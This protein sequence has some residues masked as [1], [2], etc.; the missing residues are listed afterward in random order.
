MNGIENINFVVCK[1]CNERFRGIRTCHLRKSHDMTL[2]QYLQQFP[3][4]VTTCQRA[5]DEI[6]DSLKNSE[7][8][9]KSQAS[10]ERISKIGRPGRIQTSTE[11]QKRIESRKRFFQTP[12]GLVERQ[13][14]SQQKRT[15]EA[16]QKQGESMKAFYQTPEGQKV[17]DHHSSEVW[18][19]ERRA[20]HKAS[21][22]GNNAGHPCYTKNN[23]KCGIGGF[24]EDLGFS[25]RSQMEANYIRILKYTNTPFKYEPTRFYIKN[26]EG[27]N[28]A[29]FLPDF[30]LT[31]TG[32]YV[33]TKGFLNYRDKWLLSEFHRQYPKVEVFVLLANSELWRQLTRKYRVLIPEWELP[34]G[35]S[36]LGFRK[37]RKVDE[38]ID[39]L[40]DKV[41]KK[42]ISNVKYTS[43]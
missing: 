28:I 1:I 11:K 25:V 2:P 40:I 14:M 15:P 41:V 33:E 39:V 19:D 35:K 26:S 36:K 32:N 30:L 13:R 8:F 7:K 12:E 29:S 34:P 22:Q 43:K 37:S 24:R 6:R 38:P 17:K 21:L 5:L 9:Q 27:K 23:G 10:L 20:N 42:E 18:S 16:I 3:G 4:V 31:E